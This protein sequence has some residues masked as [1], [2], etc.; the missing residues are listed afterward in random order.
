[1]GQTVVSYLIRELLGFVLFALNEGFETLE[2]VVVTCYAGTAYCLIGA[3]NNP[4][5]AVLVVEG[6][7]SYHSLNGR[8]VRVGDNAVMPVDILRVNFGNYERNGRVHSPLAGVVYNDC[9]LF[10]ENGSEL[11]AR[12]TARTEKRDVYFVSFYVFFGQLDYGVGFAHKIN[13]LA[14]ALSRCEEIIIFYGEL[15]FGQDLEKLVAY[16]TGCAD[17][18]YVILFHF[19]LLVS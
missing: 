16:H 8:A 10:S 15:F 13:N 5:D 1:M 11:C 9:A 7:E 18:G 19:I 2:E 12:R 4:L 6:F 17:Y 3:V 14:C